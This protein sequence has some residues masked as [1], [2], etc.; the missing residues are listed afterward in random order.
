LRARP[1][2]IDEL[3]RHF[4]MQLA[5]EAG[6]PCKELS[7]AALQELQTSHWSGNVRELQHAL[8][9]A[10]I[11]SGNERELLPEHFQAFGESA[12]REV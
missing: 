12:I 8:E 3:A 7:A 2:D 5:K 1:G 10:F 9:R 4:L 11:L 6:L